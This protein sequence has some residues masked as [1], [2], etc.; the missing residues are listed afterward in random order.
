MF[1]KQDLMNNFRTERYA[2]LN[3][4]RW[5]LFLETGIKLKGK[6]VFEPG[7]GI[8]DQT[9]WLLNQGVKSVIVNDGRQENLT[10]IKERFGDDKRLSYVLGDLETCLDKPEFNFT[11]DFVFCWGVYY[12]IND[13]FTD[14]H[15]MKGFRRIGP[16]IAFDYLQG[17]DTTDYYGYDNPSTSLSRYGIRPATETLV[18]NLRKIWGHV[19]MPKKQMDWHDPAAAYHPRRI[20]VASRV[21]LSS[22]GLVLQK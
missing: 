14:W 4:L 8:G 20:C 10:F 18:E 17:T 9:E 21:P 11:V 16:T 7:A 2:F 1:T 13:P 5:D 19:Y 22:P 6:T 3:K 12:H 15:I